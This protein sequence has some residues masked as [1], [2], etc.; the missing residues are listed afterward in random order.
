MVPPC[1]FSRA[2]LQVEKAGATSDSLRVDM[3]QVGGCNQPRRT[4][5][6]GHRRSPGATI[7]SLVDRRSANLQSKG[8]RMTCR[9][10]PLTE[11]V[12]VQ[13]RLM[14]G[15]YCVPEGNAKGNAGN[16]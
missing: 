9:H 3:T 4:G 6:Q 14:S 10:C 2:S 13:K 15:A 7:S 8:M 1:S 16:C 12:L 5:L 11:L